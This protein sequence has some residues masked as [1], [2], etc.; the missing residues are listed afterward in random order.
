MVRTLAAATVLVMA[1]ALGGCIAI[2]GSPTEHKPTLGQQLVDLKAALDKNAITQA[3]YDAKK[4]D[5][6]NGKN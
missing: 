2:G 3:E 5:L 1:A 6:L 4:A